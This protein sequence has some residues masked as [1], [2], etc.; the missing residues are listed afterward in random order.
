MKFPRSARI[1]RGHL[2]VAPFASVLLLLVIFVLIGSVIWT[3]GMRV[4]F[5]G[6]ELPT[7]TNELSGTDQPT[8]AVAVDADGKFYFENQ[9]V[10]EAALKS[11][12]RDAVKKNA[13]QPLT[14][15][16]QA[17]KRASYDDLL[18]LRLIANEAGIRDAWFA[19]LPRE[20]PAPAA[21]N[22]NTQ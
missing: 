9:Q 20:V 18:R 2:D 17:D 12:L 4:K 11:S 15:L 3:P 13:P 5:Q 16:I 14:L 7:A 21:P 22:S 1:F 8:I 10:G 6:L 19:V